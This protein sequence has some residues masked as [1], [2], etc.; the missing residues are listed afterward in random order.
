M[1]A[2]RERI[3]IFSNFL[4][5]C[6]QA[7]MQNREAMMNSVKNHAQS[8][9]DIKQLYTMLMQYEQSAIEYFSENDMNARL[10]THPKAGEFTETVQSSI[11]GFK[12]PFLEAAVW[13]KG[14]ML[15]IAGMLNAMKGRDIVMKKQLA[16]EG[17]K[18]DDQEEL[19]KMSLGKATLKSFFKSKQGKEQD[20]LR[21]QADIERAN[22]DIEEYRK[23][24]SFI[25]VYQG[26]FAIEKFKK[27][28][29]SQYSRMLHQMSVKSVH[30]MN[31]YA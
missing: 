24:I 25:V 27:D 3:S 12:N 10:L 11:S 1:A 22:V 20:I 30:N 28:K 2:F 29:I 15:D 4:S 26:Q 16:T 19:E 6:Q 31:L 17:K 18:R 13:I 7:N 9:Q 8:N 21:L 14:E 5:K 23:L